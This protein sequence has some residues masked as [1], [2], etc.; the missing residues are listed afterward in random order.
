MEIDQIREYCLSLTGTTE[1][2]KWGEHLTFM[3]GEKMF[4]IFGL[5]Q[6]PINASFKVSDKDYEEYIFRPG[7]IPAPYLAGAKWVA[8][9][10]ISLLSEEEW[11][12]ILFNAYEIIKAK[13]PKKVRESL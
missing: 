5:D 12:K 9:N 2:M 6:S 1:G 11:K 13:L 8:I 7:M 10:D 4:A 3:V